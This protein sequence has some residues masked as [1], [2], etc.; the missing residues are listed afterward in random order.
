MLFLSCSVDFSFLLVI[1]VLSYPLIDV[2]HSYLIYYTVNMFLFSEQVC[3][4]MPEVLDV[5]I[6]GLPE[7]PTNALIPRLL[8]VSIPSLCECV[9]LH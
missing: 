3:E 9:H 5:D 6:P 2:L 4:D 8:K 1:A 7:P